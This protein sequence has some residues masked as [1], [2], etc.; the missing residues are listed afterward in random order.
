MS[1]SLGNADILPT[2]LNDKVAGRRTVVHLL[3]QLP[4]DILSGCS[5]RYRTA[6]R[7]QGGYSGNLT[8]Q[9]IRDLL[10]PDMSA[11]VLGIVTKAGFN[12]T[13][14]QDIHIG[15]PRV[16]GVTGRRELAGRGPTDHRHCHEP[17][18]GQRRRVL[19]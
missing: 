1:F 17:M 7:P 12:V 9:I 10:V 8:I 19:N 13:R 3:V 16:S 18:S 5:D 14:A 6:G 4:R 15:T 11:V 2:M